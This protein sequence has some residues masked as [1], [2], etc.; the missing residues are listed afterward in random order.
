LEFCE[1]QNKDALLQLKGDTGAPV[2]WQSSPDGINW[3]GF[4]PADTA[5]EYSVAGVTVS[6]DFRVIVQSG[7]C[8]ADTSSVASVTYVNVPFPAANYKPADTLVCYN[9]PAYLNVVI[10]I[11]T[12]YA[13]SNTGTLTGVG[14]D[15]ITSLSF[16]MNPVATPKQTTDYVLS[17][18]NAGC[19]N[20]LL[21]TFHVQVLPP[22][23][24]D[25]GNDTS[26]VIGQPLQLNATSNDTT[27]P[28]GDSF[29]WTPI[30][31]L[32]NPNIYDPVGVYSGETDSVRYFVTATSQYGCTG[33]G[34]VLV[35][36]FKTGPDIFVPN[37]FTPGG[38]T[39]DLFRPVPVG[40]SSLQF[41]RVYNRWGQ[42]VYSTT[43]IGDGWDGRVDGRLQDSGTYVWA[44]E[45]T[46]YT[47]LRVEHKGTMILVR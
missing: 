16:T 22:I 4:V 23:I 45:G 33:T 13:W 44:V 37:A 15:Q 43:R 39:N 21:D 32:N 5:S 7:V 31:G 12:N 14:N 24:V 20:L 10:T 28:A 26:V 8:P 36:V 11:G 35:K 34:Q 47:G 42:L 30:I 27:T 40:I 1:G 41:F 29:V 3:T 17:V 38:P 2:N 18:E 46:T 6:T 25:A 9:T 19:P